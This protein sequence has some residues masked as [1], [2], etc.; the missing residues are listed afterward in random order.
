MRVSSNIHQLSRWESS[1]PIQIPHFG[2]TS[3]L[4]SYLWQN[5][6][7]TP[8]KLSPEASQQA[9][10]NVV[11]EVE[12]GQPIAGVN[13]LWNYRIL[14]Y[15][16]LGNPTWRC[17][18]QWWK[19]ING[20]ELMIQ[21][22]QVPKKKFTSWDFGKSSTYMGGLAESGCRSLDRSTAGRDRRK[23]D[24][25]R[26]HPMPGGGWHAKRSWMKEIYRKSQHL[27]GTFCL[28]LSAPRKP[29]CQGSYPM[30]Y[31]MPGYAACS[32]SLRTAD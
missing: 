24:D 25:S 28:G 16:E 8:G 1:S 30:P 4:S 21:D 7:W 2:G 14:C 22:I 13:Q 11:T 32:S 15:E 12:V 23:R 17:F 27:D 3:S 6:R 18:S 26:A 19:E 31:G 20:H 5:S 9:T 29:W 10:R